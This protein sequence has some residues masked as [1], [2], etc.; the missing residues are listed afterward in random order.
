M[1]VVWMHHLAHLAGERSM[2]RS[3]EAGKKSGAERISA[4]DSLYGL[5]ASVCHFLEAGVVN[6]WLSG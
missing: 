2:Q 6:T 3:G 1:W 5:V 4:S